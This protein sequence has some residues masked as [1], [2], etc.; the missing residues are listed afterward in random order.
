V[1]AAPYNGDGNKAYAYVFGAFKMFRN[2]DGNGSTF[3]DTGYQATVSDNSLASVYASRDS[4]GRTILILI[5]KTESVKNTSVAI[6]STAGTAEVYT[7][8]SESPNP[9]RKQNITVTSAGIVYAMPAY[10]VST[11]VIP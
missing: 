8:T 1:W 2:F 9:V 4:L 7:L 5:N 3:G 11:I 6:P 10:S